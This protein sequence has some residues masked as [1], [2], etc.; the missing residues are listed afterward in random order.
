MQIYAMDEAVDRV[1]SSYENFCNLD[2]HGR[3][4]ARAKVG[5][6]LETL[7]S[8][9]QRDADR[10]IEYGVA[11]LRELNEGHDPRFTGC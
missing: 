3:E 1:M 4:E 8:T 6:Y 11:Y 9:G 5:N 2:D 7:L 10:L